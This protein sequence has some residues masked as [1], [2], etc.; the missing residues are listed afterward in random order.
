MNADSAGADAVQPAWLDDAAA[1]DVGLRRDGQEL[2]DGRG[3]DG[4]E[5]HGVLLSLGGAGL[6]GIAHEF[7]ALGFRQGDEVLPGSAKRVRDAS[8]AIDRLM[9]YRGPDFLGNLDRFK[10]GRIFNWL[11]HVHENM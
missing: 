2:V 1:L 5:C 9:R 8:P 4:D 6:L 11:V 10:L 7:F 3:A